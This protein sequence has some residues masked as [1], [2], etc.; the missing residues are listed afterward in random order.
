M[1]DV[2]NKVGTMLHEL[3]GTAGYKLKM[4]NE[5]RSLVNMRGTPAFFITLNPSDV[6][7]PLVRLLSGDNI[8]LEY[9]AEGQALSEWDRKLLV[10]RNP[11]A[12]AKFFH[13]TISTFI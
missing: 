10:A 7:H 4:R 8:R 2:V 11:G 1:V 5:I 3:P 13:T 6:D 12:C 9:L